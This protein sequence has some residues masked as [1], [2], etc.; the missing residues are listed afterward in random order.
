M[1]QSGKMNIV[2]YTKDLEPIT[3]LDM[4]MWLQEAIER[5]GAGKVTVKGKTKTEEDTSLALQEQPPTIT[6]EVEYLCDER[7]MTHRFFVTKDEELALGV[8]PCYLPGQLQMH[9]HM[10]KVIQ[11]QRELLNKLR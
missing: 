10:I 7:G 5:Q 2:L 4:P 8:V 9:Q 11:K 1:R 3:V 6:I